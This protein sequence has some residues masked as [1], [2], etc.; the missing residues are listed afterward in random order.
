MIDTNQLKAA[1]EAAGGHDWKWWDSNSFRRLIFIDGRN[2]R[3]VLTPQEPKWTP[4]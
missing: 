3:A 2:T 1:A 4:S